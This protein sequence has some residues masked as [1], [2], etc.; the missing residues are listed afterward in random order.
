MEHLEKRTLILL[1]N[2]LVVVGNTWKMEEHG[3]EF[4]SYKAAIEIKFHKSKKLE[5]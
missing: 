1:K 2:V 3:V 5:R 4:A